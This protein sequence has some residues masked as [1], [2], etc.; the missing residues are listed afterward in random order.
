MLPTTP[1]HPNTD[2]P[3]TPHEPINDLPVHPSTR[4]QIFYPA[5]ESRSFTREDAAK[6]F[7]P[8]L[9]PADKRIPLPMLIDIQKWNNQGLSRQQRREKQI[10]KDEAARLEKEEKER[11]R[12]EWEERTQ[13]I[14]SGRRW[15]FNF[16]DISAEKTGKNGRGQHAV[17]AR[18]GMPHEDRKRG[19]V[20]IPTSVL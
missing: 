18:Y 20:K 12:A 3:I 2:R 10:E 4:Q 17:G 7:S 1:F 11:K 6:V 14:V 15:D 19:V 13:R 8:T 16:Q 9:L 5:S